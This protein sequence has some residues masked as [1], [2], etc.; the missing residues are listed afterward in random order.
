MLKCIA[1]FHNILYDM[2]YG[3]IYCTVL[4]V[5]N[6]IKPDIPVHHHVTL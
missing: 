6:T 1:S 4:T 3:V 2:S 5:G